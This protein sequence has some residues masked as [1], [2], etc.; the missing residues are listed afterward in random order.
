MDAKG[1][2]KTV[3]EGLQKK[4][5]H[6]IGATQFGKCLESNRHFVE[7]VLKTSIKSSGN[8]ELIAE[9]LKALVMVNASLNSLEVVN[10]L[11]MED[12][13]PQEFLCQ[14]FAHVIDD[15][16][17]LKD[18]GLQNRRV[19]LVCVMFRNFIKKQVMSVES[20]PEL[21]AELM[22]FCVQFSNVNEATA[23]FRLLRQNMN[24]NLNDNQVDSGS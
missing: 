16:L 18:E 1:Q 24:K 15:C 8:S 11:A 22:N 19:K 20:N 4:K 12:G 6:P 3:Y 2:P 23:L 21:S 5:R 13:L 7:S 14:Y 17:Q 9:Y 10:S